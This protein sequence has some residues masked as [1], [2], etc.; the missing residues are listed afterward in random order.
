MSIQIK[1]ALRKYFIM[2]SQNCES[3]PSLILET[4]IKAG[5]TIFQFREKGTSSLKADAKIKLG[6]QLREICR[7]HA[8][9]FIVNDDV[10]L[11]DLLDADGIHVGQDDQSVKELR[12]YFPDKIIGLSVS[13]PEELANSPLELVDYIG[14][15]PIFQTV[16]KTDAKSVVGLDWIRSLRA[17][18]P[19]LPIVGIGGINTENAESVLKAG[20]DGVSF[21][22]AITQAK[23]IE[24]SV[25]Q[26]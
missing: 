8:I 4:A 24:E 21:I 15:G 10:E 23:N 2:G 9:P 19:S 17:Q 20:A 22:S 14:A 11:V 6:K 12:K 13:T 5:I 25:K 1:P 16:T 3:N 7:E 26:L 18:F